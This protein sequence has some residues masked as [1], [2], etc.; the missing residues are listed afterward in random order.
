MLK[1]HASTW[2]HM[3]IDTN[4]TSTVR[5]ISGRAS[6]GRLLGDVERVGVDELLLWQ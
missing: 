4:S 6:C 3:E 2:A 5:I 1:F